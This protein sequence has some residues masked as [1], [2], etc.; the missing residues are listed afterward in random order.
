M[1]AI[2]Y[3]VGITPVEI[4]P[5]QHFERTVIVHA[6]AGITY[7]GNSTVSTGAG[8]PLKSDESISIVVPI[9]ENLY[10]IDGAG[11]STVVVLDSSAD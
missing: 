7:V 8:L 3:T 10:A 9:N 11:G 1:K 5:K 6:K 2:Q 4:A